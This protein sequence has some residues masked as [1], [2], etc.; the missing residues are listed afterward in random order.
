MAIASAA[1]R[2]E[3]SHRIRTAAPAEW[4]EFSKLWMAF[5]AIYGGEPD[6]RERARVMASV[7][8]N[9]NERRSLRVLRTVT[10]SVN[11][12]LE[13][14]PG[15][16]QLDRLDPK[17]RAASQRCSAMYRNKSETAIGR[18]AAVAAVLY[19]IR[20]NLIHGSKDPP[21]ERDRMLVRESL[22]VL[23]ALLPELEAACAAR[24]A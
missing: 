10:K 4:N 15:N 14:P 2:A 8:K 22:E 12:I 16:M 3:L 7:R 11:R 19:Q 18:L 20:C 23:R 17:F 1:L 9:M 24:A 5:N 13:I 6:Q 21:V